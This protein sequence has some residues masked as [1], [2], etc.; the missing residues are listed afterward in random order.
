MLIGSEKLKLNKK[1]QVIEGMSGNNYIT[2]LYSTRLKNYKNNYNNIGENIN[3]DE[4]EHTN[5]LLNQSFFSEYYVLGIEEI[6]LQHQ[7]L[8]KISNHLTAAAKIFSDNGYAKSKVCSAALKATIDYA[9]VHFREEEEFMKILEY[10][11]LS[12]HMREHNKIE[13]ELSDLLDLVN[14]RQFMN[15]VQRTHFI[16]YIHKTWMTHISTYDRKGYLPFVEKNT[17][18]E[19]FLKRNLNVEDILGEQLSFNLDNKYSQNLTNIFK[20]QKWMKIH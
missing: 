12:D 3:Y 11:D 18:P 15:Q 13:N 10:P 4:K 1:I 5:F 14:K 6:D 20:K 7:E 19:I 16:N 17:K 9:G 8:F 2:D